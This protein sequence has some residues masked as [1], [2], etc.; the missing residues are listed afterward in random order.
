MIASFLTFGMIFRANVRVIQSYLEVAKIVIV[1]ISVKFISRNSRLPFIFAC[2]CTSIILLP[3][4]NVLI[5]DISSLIGG[6]VIGSQ[7]DETR[8][9]KNYI[10]FCGVNILLILYEIVLVGVFTQTDIFS[11][12][13]EHIEF[14][15]GRISNRIITGTLAKVLLA[16]FILIDSMFSSFVTFVLTQ[17]VMKKVKGVLNVSS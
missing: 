14:I 2:L 10:V 7:K 4:Q 13:G 5:Y 15:L 12:Y 9:I 11:M 6:Y 17:F 16:G 8:K 3:I 1:A